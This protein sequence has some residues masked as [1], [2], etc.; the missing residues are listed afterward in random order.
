MAVHDSAIEEVEAERAQISEHDRLGGRRIDLGEDVGAEHSADNAGNGEPEEQ[1]PVD[2]L[3][4]DMADPGD[5]GGE[6]FRG[7]DPG[8]GRGRGTPMLIS[9]VEE[10]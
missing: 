10:I 2:I 5:G 4:R 1:P 6:G 9:K 3:M 7:M 8:R